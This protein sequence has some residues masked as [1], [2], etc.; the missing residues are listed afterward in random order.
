MKIQETE[1][2]RQAL[3]DGAEIPLVYVSGGDDGI[4][5]ALVDIFSANASSRGSD[6]NVIRLNASGSKSDA[7]ERFNEIAQ[8]FPMFDEKSIVLMTGCA[9]GTKVPK[10]SKEFLKS[11]PEHVNAIFSGDRKTASSPLAK[12]AKANGRVIDFKDLKDAQARSMAMSGARE[13]GIMLDSAAAN[14]LV[15][16]VGTEIG[17]IDSA[18]KSLSGLV[19]PDGGQIRVGAMDLGGLVRRT[20][21]HAPWD[22]DE[23]IERRDLARAVKV[24]IRELQDAKDPRVIGLF[25]TVLRRT[26][27]ILIASDLVADRVPKTEAMDRLGIHWPFMYDRLVD[28]TRRYSSAELRTF[29][30]SSM[31]LDIRM[32]RGVAG[33]ETRI[34]EILT[35]LMVKK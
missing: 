19:P 31:D 28:A 22:M 33:P 14:A 35:S 20:R 16:M 26:R 21:K 12:L 29:I 4:T 10:E 7:W 23:A 8:S 6:V 32:K 11:P 1:N 9:G 3:A 17:A 24:A 18:L 15:D 34:V 30:K 13:M 25:N 27:M 5:D 2:I